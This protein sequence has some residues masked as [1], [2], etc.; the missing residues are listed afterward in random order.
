MGMSMPTEIC[1]HA[2]CVLIRSSADDALATFDKTAEAHW[3]GPQE[4]RLLRLLAKWATLDL[5]VIMSLIVVTLLM[6]LSISDF[7]TTDTVIAFLAVDCL[8]DVVCFALK[9]QV[10]QKQF[11]VCCGKM[12]VIPYMICQ[13]T[14]SGIYSDEEEELYLRNKKERVM[15]VKAS[16]IKGRNYD[17]AE[18]IVRRKMDEWTTLDHEL[19]PPQGVMGIAQMYCAACSPP[20]QDASSELLVVGELGL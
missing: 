6:V 8:I 17:L 14:L 4:W 2:I 18:V 1:S 16:E 10:N 3:P 11:Q 20:Q 12:S 19:K 15:V 5:W 7:V 13:R 9:F